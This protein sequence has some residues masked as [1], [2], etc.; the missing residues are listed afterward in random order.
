MNLD[1]RTLLHEA[2]IAYE[3]VQKQFTEVNTMTAGN[4]KKLCTA[5]ELAL[6]S[7]V[8]EKEG[9]IPKSFY[10]HDLNKIAVR[11]GLWSLLPER[12][13]A[14][15]TNLTPFNLNPDVRYPSGKAYATLVNSTSPEMWSHRLEDTRHIIELCTAAV[16]DPKLREK[17][18]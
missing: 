7:L 13:Q 17:I 18:I 6:K 10:T 8:V 4:C 2:Q 11:T 5:A 14:T 15:L 3:E 16:T 9:N 12:C 1:P